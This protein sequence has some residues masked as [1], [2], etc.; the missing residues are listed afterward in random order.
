MV[1]V[2]QI[3]KVIL[4]EILNLSLNTRIFISENMALFLQYDGSKDDPDWR[5]DF[6]YLNFI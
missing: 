4:R 3:R 5:I 6:K 1:L 2:K